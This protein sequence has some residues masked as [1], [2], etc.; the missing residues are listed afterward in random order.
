LAKVYGIELTLDE[1][2]ALDKLPDFP[3]VGVST[4]FL[5]I[6]AKAAM[7]AHLKARPRLKDEL[8]GSF[9]TIHGDNDHAIAA[10]L[11]MVNVADEFVSP[12]KNKHPV[13]ERPEVVS[14]HRQPR[15]AELVISGLRELQRRSR[16]GDAGFDALGVVVV[17]CKNDGTP[18]RVISARSPAP[19]QEDDFDYTRFIERM[20]H[21]YS[22]RFSAI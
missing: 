1:A 11:V 21:L 19:S 10:G 16:V 9:Q 4:V 13:G 14:Q 18:V 8:T 2:A 5:A 6:E 17:D 12:D 15:D 7:T 22:T 20:A 3:I